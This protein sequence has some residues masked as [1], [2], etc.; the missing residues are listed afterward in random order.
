MYA[1]IDELDEAEL[2]EEEKTRRQ[3]V[4][5]QRL[6]NLYKNIQDWLPE[7]LQ[8]I[9]NDI[10]VYDET[11]RYHAPFISICRN[12]VAEPDAFIAAFFP[13]N[14]STVLSKGLVE[15]SGSM[16]EENIFYLLNDSLTRYHYET[17]NNE[18]W[19]WLKASLEGVQAVSFDASLL[20]NLLKRSIFYT[21]DE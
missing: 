7:N 3:Q 13:K 11:G 18:G 15:I 4:Y 19:Y 14:S 12:D 2:S 6:N 1:E 10:E 20:L 21:D 17:V 5:L 8:I 9:W 16:G